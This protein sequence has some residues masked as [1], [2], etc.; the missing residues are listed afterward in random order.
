LASLLY[1][2]WLLLMAVSSWAVCSMVAAV[3]MATT[4][5]AGCF[6]VPEMNSSSTADGLIAAE[7]NGTYFQ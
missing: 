4:A 5:G 3:M 6:V 7:I 1:L 2:G